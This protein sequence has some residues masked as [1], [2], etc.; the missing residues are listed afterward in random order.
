MPYTIAAIIGLFV[1]HLVSRVVMRNKAKVMVYEKFLPQVILKDMAGQ[2]FASIAAYIGTHQ[3][4][5]R[6]KLAVDGQLGGYGAGQALKLINAIQVLS[7][8]DE[9]AAELDQLQGNDRLKVITECLRSAESYL[10]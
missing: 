4:E 9:I 5:L 2:D 3:D 8:D 1:L 6:Q 10:G 7:E